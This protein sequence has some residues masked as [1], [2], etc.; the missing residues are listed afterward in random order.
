MQ[1]NYDELL[2][3]YLSLF[4]GC[5]SPL[6]C[7]DSTLKCVWQSGGVFAVGDNLMSYLREPVPDPMHELTEASVYK[8]DKFY[9]CRIMPVK[10]EAGE[11]DAYICELIGKEAARGIAERSDSLSDILPLYNAVEYNTAAVWKS[12]EKLRGALIGSRDYDSL[13]D[14]LEIEKAMSNISAACGNAFEY[15]SMMYGSFSA[16]RIDAGA[17][18]R[19]LAE[20]CNAALAKCGRRIEPLIEPDDLTIYA[21]SRRTV[22]ALVNA[23]QNALLYSPRDSEPIL[24]VYRRDIRGRSFVEIRLSNENIMFTSRD[25]K[26]KVDINFSYQRL[27]YGIP[28]IKRFAKACGGSFSMEDEG[29]RVVVTL[30]LPAAE[31]EFGSGLT[32]KSP[33]YCFYNTGVPDFTEIMM[34]EVVQ[35]FGEKE[36]T[37]S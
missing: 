30:T 2:K 9:C 21:D 24:A 26:E 7:F 8:D 33:E 28:I 15:I 12:A 11:S 22:V 14:V 19:S 13:S 3:P 27:G 25:F 18:C 36:E 6:V 17:L 4:S 1:I 35:F 23:V 20:Q 37:H 10:N 5:G 31:E 32:L 16:V 29:G 34:R